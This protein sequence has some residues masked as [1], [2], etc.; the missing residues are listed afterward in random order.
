[1]GKL[2]FSGSPTVA[3]GLNGFR[4][5]DIRAADAELAGAL[6][7]DHADPFDRMLVAQAERSSMTLVTADR[8]VLGYGRAPMMS[9]TI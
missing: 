8:A 4:E 3:I 5:L 6:D 7:W 1:L 2:E 9:A